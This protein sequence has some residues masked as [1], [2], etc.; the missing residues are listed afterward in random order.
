MPGSL[1]GDEKD[2]AENAAKAGSQSKI[3][4]PKCGVR[5]GNLPEHI[6]GCDG[7]E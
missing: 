1:F 3:P 7:D 6:P 5:K 2:A 4:C